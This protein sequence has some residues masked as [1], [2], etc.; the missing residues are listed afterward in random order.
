MISFSE[1]VIYSVWITHFGAS[2]ISLAP[3]F[4]KSQNALILLLLL[5]KL[6]PLTL[7][8]DLVRYRAA[9]RPQN[10]FLFQKGVVAEWKFCSDS[11]FYVETR[12]Q[13]AFVWK[14]RAISV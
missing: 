8:C 13:T 7:D 12:L 9:E 3:I 11:S 6:Q 1:I 5:S 4:Y 14:T 10:G 2:D